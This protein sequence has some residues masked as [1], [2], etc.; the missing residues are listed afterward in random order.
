[1]ATILEFTGRQEAQDEPSKAASS[2][3]GETAQ[4]IFFPGIRIERYDTD[5]FIE[6]DV[7]AVGCD[8]AQ[9]SKA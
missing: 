6:D 9:S 7:E 4:I 2:A 3:D 1:M 8:T 5:P